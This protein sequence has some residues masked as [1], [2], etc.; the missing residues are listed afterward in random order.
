MSAGP[1]VSTRPG[2]SRAIATRR[3]APIGTLTRKIQR[4]PFSSP[5][6]AM[7]APPRIGPIAEETDTV[8]PKSPNATP[9]SEPRNRDW[10]R[11]ELCGVSSPAAK[12]WTSRAATSTATCGARPAAALDRT[13]PVRPMSII[14]RRP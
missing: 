7:S 4:H 8:N 14:R 2:T 12:P 6:A 10:I 9:R 5:K 3:T 13:N 11:P 1:S